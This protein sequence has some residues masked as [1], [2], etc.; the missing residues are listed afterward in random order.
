MA[1]GALLLAAC[2]APPESL[3]P[4]PEQP[5]LHQGHYLA[6]DGTRLPLRRWGSEAEAEAVLIA[7]HSFGDHGAAFQDL[8]PWF[9]ARGYLV[10]APDVRGFGEAGEH[11]VWAGTCTLVADL[12]DLVTLV[13]AEV[14]D[15]P[16]VV[17]GESMGGGLALLSAAG[18][19]ACPSEAEATPDALI[20]AAPAVRGG[21]PLRYFWDAMISAGDNLA[22]DLTFTVGR[23]RPSTLEP[24]FARRLAEDPLIVRDVRMDTYAGLIDLA[25]KATDAVPRVQVPSL[26]LHGSRDRTVKRVSVE[27][28]VA[29]SA[30]P[31]KLLA[32]RGAP[33]MVLH[34]RPSEDIWQDVADWL[35]AQGLP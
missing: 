25:D 32:Y 15:R 26:Y 21:L 14:P 19:E 11:G 24:V 6:A 7:L 20:L 4:R 28:A 18:S 2:S 22:P 5:A 29:E 10:L 17:L 30:G 1:V 16:L 27:K 12:S 31:A 23:A 9:A 35:Q 8:G 34:R 13:K 33:H 3:E